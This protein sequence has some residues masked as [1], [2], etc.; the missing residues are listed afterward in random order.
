MAWKS[1]V[2]IRRMT[3][4]AAVA[5]PCKAI[6]QPRQVLLPTTSTFKIWGEPKTLSTKSNCQDDISIAKCLDNSQLSKFL[7]LRI[8]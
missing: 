1:M 2:I 8:V 7:Y 6:L 3:I 4:V 5:V